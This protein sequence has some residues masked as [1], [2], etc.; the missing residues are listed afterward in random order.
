[1]L[2]KN[3]HVDPHKTPWIKIICSLLEFFIGF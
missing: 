2:Q 3:V 1:M